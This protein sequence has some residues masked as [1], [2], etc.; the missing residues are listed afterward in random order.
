MPSRIP[1][2][3]RT[4]YTE[5]TPQC[6]ETLRWALQQGCPVD[7]D[8]QANMGNGDAAWEAL[9]DFMTKSTADIENPSP[10]TLSTLSRFL[11][12]IDVLTVSGPLGNLL[13]PPN[14]LAFPIYQ[15]MNHPTYRAYQNQIAALSLFSNVYIKFIPPAWGAPTPATPAP[16]L[17]ALRATYLVAS[18]TPL[19]SIPS[20]A[21]SP[22]S[23]TSASG[24]WAGKTLEAEKGES[25]QLKEWK[26]RIRMYRKYPA[27]APNGRSSD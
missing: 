24:L 21:L 7:I 15:L 10:I 13:P 16:G 9:E 26:R 4:V 11:Y 18:Q 12:R 22:S 3:L 23:A 14:A 17:H 20:S 25:H 8:I 19:S 2:S 6:I 27:L 1:I 5:N